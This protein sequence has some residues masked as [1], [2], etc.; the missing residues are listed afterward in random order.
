MRF[1]LVW[2]VGGT[3]LATIFSSVGPVYFQAFGFGDTFAEQ[4]QKLAEFNEISPVWALE[5][6]Q[7][8]LDNYRTDGPV[9]GISAM[10]SMHV[11]SS[12]LLAIFGFSY[13]RV[14][15]WAMTVFAGLILIGSVHLGWHYAIDG[16]FS[17]A[18]AGF[19][20]WAAKAINRWFADPTY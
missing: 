4:M 8:L 12:A 15:G 5:V 10:P 20:W 13:S 14:V 9:K 18:L 3:I 7:L 16:Y 6:Q 17:I 1:S 19:C 2:I 11:A